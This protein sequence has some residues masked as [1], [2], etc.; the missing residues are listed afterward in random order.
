[1]SA[2]LAENGC[3]GPGVLI[4]AVLVLR[5]FRVDPAVRAANAPMRCGALPLLC[6]DG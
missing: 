6:G 2:V 5:R 3:Y 1:M 4:A